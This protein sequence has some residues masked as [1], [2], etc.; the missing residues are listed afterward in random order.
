MGLQNFRTVNCYV[1]LSAWWLPKKGFCFVWL[2]GSEAVVWLG[3]R[4]QLRLQD[5][6]GYHPWQ[7]DTQCLPSGICIC[8]MRS[9]P[10]VWCWALLLKPELL[11]LRLLIA[12]ALADEHLNF[13][14]SRYSILAV[15]VSVSTF[16]F[17][18]Q[19]WVVVQYQPEP[20]GRGLVLSQLRVEGVL[21]QPPFLA[22]IPTQPQ[23]MITSHQTQ[24]HHTKRGKGGA[25]HV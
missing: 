7:T 18:L 25:G 23:H 21:L 16:S 14:K 15:S 20:H 4:S 10:A 19:N 9:M 13:S 5:K 6:D 22:A 11:C 2:S 12:A 1:C 17:F 3:L 24:R 8:K